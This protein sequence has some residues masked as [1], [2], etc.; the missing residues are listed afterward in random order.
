[1]LAQQ[2]SQGAPHQLNASPQWR[3]KMQANLDALLDLSQHWQ[4]LA[5]TA[6]IIPVDAQSIIQPGTVLQVVPEA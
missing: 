6:N 4:S 2:S 3:E 5:S 1:L